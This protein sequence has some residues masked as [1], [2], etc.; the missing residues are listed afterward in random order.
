[1][2]DE[3]TVISNFCLKYLEILKKVII[4]LFLLKT[5]LF[6]DVTPKRDLKYPEKGGS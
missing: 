4:I 6:W 3:K 2:L 1:V 5:K